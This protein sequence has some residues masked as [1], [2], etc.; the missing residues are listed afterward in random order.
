[1]S[2]LTPDIP[3]TDYILD[4]ATDNPHL[5]MRKMPKGLFDSEKR[6]WLRDEANI[7]KGCSIQCE[8]KFASTGLYYF[9]SL[10]DAFEQEAEECIRASKRKY[11]ER[12]PQ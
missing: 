11:I 2:K 6:E 12:N 5:Q 7:L 9:K 4:P 3:F 8:N 10:A 1:M